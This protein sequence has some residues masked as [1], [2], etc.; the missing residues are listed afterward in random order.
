VGSIV[1][2]HLYPDEAVSRFSFLVSGFSKEQGQYKAGFL[3]ALVSR[4]AGS[5][6]GA[7]VLAAM[8]RPYLEGWKGAA[9]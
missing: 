6:Q 7:E 4:R 3:V 1:F 8:K 5:T 9:H 2:R